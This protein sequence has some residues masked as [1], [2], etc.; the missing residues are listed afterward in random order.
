MSAKKAKSL[1]KQMN[2]HPNDGNERQYERGS[3]GVMEISAKSK[4]FQ[5]LQAK[6]EM[7]A[8]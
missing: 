4:R 2:Y 8:G 5:Y 1:R 6:K 7:K 3:D